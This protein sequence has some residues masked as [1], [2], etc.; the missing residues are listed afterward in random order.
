MGLMIGAQPPV[1]VYTAASSKKGLLE[2]H[3]YPVGIVDHAVGLHGPP[4][5]MEMVDL[6]NPHQQEKEEDGLVREWD[7]FRIEGD[8]LLNDGEGKWY[9]FVTTAGYWLVKWYEGMLPM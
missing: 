5:L 4:G 1:Q 2:L 9:A 8:K 6:A 3:T 7:E